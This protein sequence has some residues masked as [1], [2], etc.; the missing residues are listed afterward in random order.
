M[1]LH[2]RDLMEA[3]PVAAFVKDADGRYVYANPHLLATMG[4]QMGLDWHGK[5]DA[6]MWPPEAAAMMRAHDEAILRGSGLQ[7]FSRVMLLD[8]GPH[9]VLLIELPLPTADSRV[10]VGGIGVD[11]TEHAKKG[12]ERDR[13][14]AVV[15]QATESVMMVDLDS[16]I[17]YVNP[18]FERVTGYSRDEVIGQNP[19][20]LKSGRQPPS[21][22]DAMWAAIT[23]GLPWAADLIN[24]R[25]DGSL[26]TE[27]AVISPIRDA[28]GAVTSYVA[29]KR[30]VTEERALAERSTLFARQRVLIGETISS[31]RADDT[32]E[33]T[34]QAICRRVVSLT[35]LTGAN[36]LLFRPDGRALPIGFVVA[37]EPDPPLRPLTYQRSQYLRERAALGPWIEPWMDRPSHPYNQLLN[38]LGVHLVAY[39]PVR[40]REKVIGLLMVHSEARSNAVA[41]AEVLPALVE[42]ADLAGVLIG[43]EVA[44][45]TQVGRGADRISGIIL[46]RA[47]QLVFQPIVDLGRNVIVGYEALTRF[48]DGT[49]PEV[50]FA[51]AAAVGLGAELEIATLQ[52]ALAA[53]EALPKSAWLNLNASPEL[54]MA[55]EPLRS[56]LRESRRHFVL[57]VTEHAAIAD[58]PAFRAAMAT[59][60]PSVELAVDDAGAGFASLRHI[61]ELRPAFVKL[62]RWLVAGL[63]ADNARQAMIVGLRH[64]ARATGCRLIAEGI[65]TDRELAI[66]RALDIELGQGYLLGRPGSDYAAQGARR[67]VAP[68]RNDAPPV[69]TAR[70]PRTARV[71]Q[72]AEDVRPASD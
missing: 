36:M 31:L 10:G 54:I 3:A 62:D 22:Y 45:R 29:V 38:R 12:A 41:V 35:G 7:V 28:S 4:K 15:E 2:F 16:R 51:K 6:D 56:L 68:G 33:A 43:G 5:T 55:G 49:D 59:L 21:F 20:L 39:A 48:R 61:L 44:K 25:K 19:R 46:D 53:S 9:T 13:L 18:A 11:V 32:P 50:M 14:A 66:L 65:E 30:D 27:E 17:T 63:D 67:E 37:G 40:H 69:R 42:F 57:E 26:F 64:F 72:P 8:D 34:A 47:F 24:R 1:A 70:A 23:S 60:G 71:L 58:Y 52:A